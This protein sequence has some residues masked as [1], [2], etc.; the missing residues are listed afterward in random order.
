MSVVAIFGGRSEIGLE[1]ACRLA[2]GNTVV[3]AARPGSLAEELLRVE[4]AG[5]D[6]L[7][8]EVHDNPA[9]ALSDGPNMLALEQLA[10]LLADLLAID[11]VARK[12]K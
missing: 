1:V 12:H 3:L 9:E 8:M 5:V 2:P 6:A 4:A 11:A 7:F 10:P